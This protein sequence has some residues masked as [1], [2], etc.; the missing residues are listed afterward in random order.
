M[1]AIDGHAAS[2]D[3]SPDG[4]L[5]AV[6]GE[7]G[8]VTLWNA[9]TLAP[10]GELDGLQ[11]VPQAVAFSPDGKLIAA[12]EA[13]VSAEALGGE[14]QPLRVWDVR[15]RTLTAFRGRTSANLI[16]FSPDGELIAAAATQRGT[17]IRDTRTGRLVKRLG[18]G[19]LSGDADFSRSVAFSPDGELLFVGEYDGT[20]R[21][22]STDTWR[23]VGQPLRAHTA[24]I[25]FP[26]FTPDGR[27]LVTAAADG[28]VVLWDVET[29]KT[30]GGPLELAPRTFTSAAFSPDGARLYAVSTRGEGI[31][32][33][34]S[35]EA[36]K[37][38]ARSP[39]A[40]SPRR[41]GQPRCP[42]GPTRPS[43]R[44]TDRP[45]LPVLPAISRP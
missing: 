12:A 7:G 31:S 20:G 38:H 14:P 30:I 17:E 8:Q 45:G 41:N 4:R 37:R 1:R 26:E 44:A 34:M 33:N 10:A 19:D 36:W 35:P 39:G 27:T 22:I 25:T 18:Y 23:P 6:T 5:L 40:S 2:V 21:L 29:Q 28:T 32:F 3:F 15:R 9:Q 16:A 24:R 11:R 13:Q 43:A 42:D